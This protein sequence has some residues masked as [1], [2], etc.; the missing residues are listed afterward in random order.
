MALALD[1]RRIALNIGIL[2]TNS[3]HEPPCGGGV[4]GYSDP[5]SANQTVAKLLRAGASVS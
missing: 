4:E 3:F 5:G 1:R 2:P